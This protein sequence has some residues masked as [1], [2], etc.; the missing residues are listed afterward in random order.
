MHGTLDQ[1]RALHP[2]KWLLIRLD[3]SD[4]EE[5]TLLVAHKDPERVDEELDRQS[6]QR[7]IHPEPLYVTYSLPE[8]QELPAFAL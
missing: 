3:G 5:G 8:D 1:L 2:G 6:Q 7:L 4:A